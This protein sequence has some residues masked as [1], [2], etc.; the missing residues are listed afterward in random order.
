[1]ICDYNFSPDAQK[2]IQ[3][4]NPVDK[5]N[6]YI[7]QVL[8]EWAPSLLSKISDIRSALQKA[9]QVENLEILEKLQ[10]TFL[11]ENYKEHFTSLIPKSSEVFP[12]VLSHNDVQENNLL[13]QHSDNS[14]LLLID[15]EY[16]G[17]NPMAMDLANWIN[18]T[19]LDN[20]YPEKNGIAWYTQ[21]IMD[22]EEVRTMI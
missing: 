14:K 12:I 19:M 15:Y 10:K 6:L 9:G 22:S 2:R 16:A 21:N 17:W 4:I 8:Y 11:F 18:E 13:I 7:Q 3:T 20:S 5:D 1:M